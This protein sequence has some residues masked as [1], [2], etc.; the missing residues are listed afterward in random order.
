M[1]E[2]RRNHR[3]NVEIPVS[4]EIGDPKWLVFATTLDVSATGLSLK[5]NEPL[6]VGQVLA[7]TVGLADDRMVKVG[8]QVIWV[9]ERKGENGTGYHVG[10]K[11][12]D[13]MDQDE[14]DFVRFVAKKMFEHFSRPKDQPADYE[15]S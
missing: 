7:L 2:K 15:D 14:I 4:F 5:L 11:I 10:V 9:K 8:A 12:I 13:K 1:R 6:A 3:M